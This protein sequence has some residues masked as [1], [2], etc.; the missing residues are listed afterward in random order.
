MSN[1]WKFSKKSFRQKKRRENPI[2]RTISSVCCQLM[3]HRF[4]SKIRSEA[5]RQ[6]H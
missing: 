3:S 1:L 4:Q 2:G 5:S 6:R